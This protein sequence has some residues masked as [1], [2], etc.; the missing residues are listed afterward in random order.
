MLIIV[1]CKIRAFQLLV[2]LH[3]NQSLQLEWSKPENNK[4]SIVSTSTSTNHDTTSAISTEKSQQKTKS[5][6]TTASSVTRS[7]ISNTNGKEF[8]NSIQDEK[9]INKDEN[10]NEQEEDDDS[11]LQSSSE[12]V[13]VPPTVQMT[14]EKSIS[15]PAALV[16]LL[17]A[18]RVSKDE[19]GGRG[20]PTRGGRSGR[21]NN[22]QLKNKNVLNQIQSLTHTM[23]SRTSGPKTY[24]KPKKTAESTVHSTS[25]SATTNGV[26]NDDSKDNHRRRRRVAHDD[27]EEEEDDDD[28]DNDEEE[29]EDDEDNKQL[30]SDTNNKLNITSTEDDAKSSNTA[31]N[32]QTHSVE[33][34]ATTATV[35]TAAEEGDDDE[36]PVMFKVCGYTDAAVELAIEYINKII[37]GERIKDAILSLKTR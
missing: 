3:N 17:L 4:R 6:A 33:L 35:T 32:T 29:D 11:Q 26:S 22:T 19:R 37:G 7:N 10:D 18:R 13:I 5:D 25:S 12:P 21:G 36:P 23:I 2:K 24:I 16:G 27:D 28:D 34:A 9:D 15:I 8:T 20:G 14:V 31:S 1:L 30:I